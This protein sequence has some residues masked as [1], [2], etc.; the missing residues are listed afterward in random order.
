MIALYL[1]IVN[2]FATKVAF[3]HYFPHFCV[4]NNKSPSVV[5]QI[6]ITLFIVL[7]FFF[8]CQPERSYTEDPEARLSFTLD[9][10]FFDTVFTT[11]GTVTE[12]F[13]IKNPHN[14]FIN[15][16]EISL[17]GGNSSVFRINVDGKPGISFSNI[18][19]APKDSMYVF[20][21]AT[22]DPNE[23]PDILRIQDSIV[24]LT[25]GNIQDIDLVAW[26]QDVHIIRDSI[27][28]G[29][30]TWTA[31][32]P[33]LVLNY[34]YVDSAAALTID[35]GATVHMHRDALLYVDGTLQVN[36]TMEEPVRFQ[37]DRL[38]EFYKDKPGQWG[39]IYLSGNSRGNRIDHAEIINGTLGI[40]ISAE[41]ES[42]QQPDL[43]V[44]N[45]IINHMSFNGIYALNATVTGA[46][47]VIGD[48][49]GSCVGLIYGGD[50]EFTHC[51][52]VNS[53]PSWYSNRRLPALFLADYFGNY[54]AD[55]N[56]VIYTGGEFEQ[57]EFRNSIIYG[58][59]RTELVIDS[60]D[61]SP[62]NYRFDHCLTRIDVDSL[63]YTKDTLFSDIINNENPL[64]DSVPVF[65]SLDTLSP[66]IDAGL[67]AHAIGIPFDFDGNNRLGDEAPDLGAYERIEEG[68]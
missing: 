59:A 29:A 50:Y 32:K 2:G 57:A 23:S 9:T 44:T 61:G 52:L 20:V 36:G 64:L 66:A 51:T 5:R 28:S 42:G 58:N 37:G 13:R 6:F 24:F 31:D 33:Y 38:E 45:S 46:N 67:P 19:I 18:E 3:S 54:D 8:A 14:Q 10:V 41:P 16:D 40:L 22:L 35:A 17:A 60:Y 47:L 27:L 63:D 11:F 21:E 65:Y 26:G 43:E 34:A 48:C 39:M 49:G 30:V 55:G 68:N 25:N 1:H 12:S 56:L 53:W 62:M 15:I 4:H 7:A